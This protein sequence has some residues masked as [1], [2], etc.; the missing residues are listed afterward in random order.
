MVLQ[1]KMSHAGTLRKLGRYEDAH[2]LA[3][4]TFAAQVRRFGE[5]HP[6]T[7]ASKVCL[8]LATDSIG[9]PAEALSL[10]DEALDGYSR[11]MGEDHPFVPICAVNKAVVL[12]GLSEAYEAQATDQDALSKLEAGVLGANHHYA[13]CAKAGLAKDYYLLGELDAAVRLL[14]EVREAFV[15]SLGERHPYSLAVTLNLN[16]ARAAMGDG[17]HDVGSVLTSLVHVLGRDHPEVRAA[18]RGELLEC[19]IEPTAL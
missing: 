8:A 6:N 9:R 18:Q 1:A 19:D 15:A 3:T 7:L 11:E 10:V 13:L 2:R 14:S 16:R 17:E 12:R 4:E 5:E